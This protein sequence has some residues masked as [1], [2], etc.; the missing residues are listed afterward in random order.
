MA[1]MET[2]VMFGEW[3]IWEDR[4]EGTCAIPHEYINDVPDE[5][6]IEVIQQRVD[7]WGARMSAQGYLDCTPWVVF[8]TVEDAYQYLEDEYEQEE[9]DTE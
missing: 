2:E 1:F 4:Y 6:I 7:G 8:D 9:E 5:Q 3:F